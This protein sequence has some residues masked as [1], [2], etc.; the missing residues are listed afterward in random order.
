[1]GA[2][3]ILAVLLFLAI[4]AGATTTILWRRATRNPH[5]SEPAAEFT[6]DKLYRLHAITAMNDRSAG[7][8]FGL[9]EDESGTI[10]A[11][12]T[13]SNCGA[14]KPGDC[15][16]SV[17][18]Q[19]IKVDRASFPGSR[20]LVVTSFPAQGPPPAAGPAAPAPQLAPFEDDATVAVG[21]AIW[22]GNR[23]P[24]PDDATILA[25]P[26]AVFATA[27][28]DL[29]ETLGPS[30]G[31]DPIADHADRTRM[32]GAPD[33]AFSDIDPNAGLPFLR[34][35]EGPD[36]GTDFA[37]AFGHSTIGRDSKMTVALSDDASS[38]LHCEVIYR[39]NG[40]WIRD[41]GSTNGTWCNDH[42]IAEHELMFGDRIKV[43]ETEMVFTCDGHELRAKD[44][45][46]AIE[47]FEACVAR[48]PD[49][50]QALKVLAFLLER[51]V[52]RRP[53]AGPIWQR[54]ATLEAS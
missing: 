22:P 11:Y 31:P 7:S 8:Y 45:S 35:V 36:S 12:L 39:R 41:A 47:A 48:G 40:F 18:G 51:D 15:V 54:I 2:V 42:R 9:A 49:F 50:V 6:A 52:A 30:I 28:D 53:E 10:F 5:K 16:T 19:L 34:V 46:R 37:L 27:Q 13:H 1:M 43:A 4:A 23:A 32:V 26:A 20:P 24:A 29:E 44:A 14:L 21:A 25:T 38:R 3:E 33:Q 17:S